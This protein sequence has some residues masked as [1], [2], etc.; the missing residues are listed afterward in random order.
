MIRDCPDWERL[1]RQRTQ[2]SSPDAHP[3]VRL[4]YLA[5]YPAERLVDY[6][7]GYPVVR[8]AERL[9]GCPVENPAARQTCHWIDRVPE[10]SLFRHYAQGFVQEQCAPGSAP[11]AVSERRECLCDNGHTMWM[12]DRPLPC[13]AWHRATMLPLSSHFEAD[14]I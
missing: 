3:Y 6:L 14:W 9:A 11:A 7:A 10:H 8:P 2:F 5:G 4:D 13:G 1:P 12:T